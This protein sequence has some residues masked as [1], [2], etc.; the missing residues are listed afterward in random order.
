[1]RRQSPAS[2]VFGRALRL[3]RLLFFRTH[4]SLYAFESRV[5]SPGARGESE[6][7]EEDD[8]PEEEEEGG[9]DQ[10]NAEF[11]KAGSQDNN[12]GDPPRGTSAQAITEGQPKA[13]KVEPIIVIDEG[14]T[15]DGSR[16]APETAAVKSE[17]APLDDGK[18]L[19][20]EEDAETDRVKQ[21][22][23]LNKRE[24]KH[25]DPVQKNE[26]PIESTTKLHLPNP[27]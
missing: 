18:E 25:D 6:D 19:K 9:I 8:V 3:E 4:C 27:E 10:K 5:S 17:N 2:C 1:M 15:A 26:K 14:S 20:R 21:E 23:E 16:D 24:A 13:E 7:D 12:A 11:E 22:V